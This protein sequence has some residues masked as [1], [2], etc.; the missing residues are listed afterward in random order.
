MVHLSV[1]ARVEIDEG[2]GDD[3]LPRTIAAG[4]SVGTALEK[5]FSPLRPLPAI[6]LK[7]C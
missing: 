2:I 6:A 7:A 5:V 3:V 4:A 1:S